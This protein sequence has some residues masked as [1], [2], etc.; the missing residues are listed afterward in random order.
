MLDVRKD[1]PFYSSE[2]Q[3]AYLDNSA[4]TLK[5][6]CVIDTLVNYYANE[7][8]NVHRGDYALSYKV[9]QEYE[10]VRETV[11]RFINARESK[12]IV[13]TTGTT[14][15]LNMVAY[16]MGECKLTSDDVIVVDVAE[17]ASNLL[18]WFRVS[19]KTGAKIRYVPLTEEGRITVE[20]L[21][22]VLDEHVKIVSI[23]QVGN[24]L[25]YIAPIKE[26]VKAAHEVGAIFVVD[27]AQSL[28]H[29]KIDVQDLDCDFFCFSAHKACGPTGAG[30]LYGKY[31]LLQEM[32]PLILGGG[33]NARF[34]SK[35]NVALKDAPY[36]YEAGTQAIGEILAMKTAL[37]YLESVGIENIQKHEKD[38]HDYAIERLLPLDNIEI[39]NPNSD[40]GIIAFNVKGVFAQDGATFLSTKGV[41]C[42]AGNHCAKCLV[43]FL[44]EGNSIRCSIYFYNTKEDIDRLIDAC[45]EANKDTCLDVFF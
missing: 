19:E 39:Y 33:N 9:S 8:V 14:M 32:E 40:T 15:G 11:R 12:E 36:K 10:N 21:K 18:P 42:R 23:A 38:L 35:Q 29:M 2:E 34:D 7:S 43:D 22:S 20:N 26:L 13:F 45:K 37:E 25:G 6:Q 17:H 5:P 44:G 41:A 27:G 28:P 16:G 1:F 24:V 31:E 4:T 30:A 3:I